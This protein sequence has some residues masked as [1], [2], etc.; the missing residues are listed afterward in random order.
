MTGSCLRLRA[1]V[2]RCLLLQIYLFSEISGA[3]FNPAVT[4]TQFFIGKLGAG[5]K[6]WKRLLTYFGVQVR[7]P[8]NVA[9]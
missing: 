9:K 1:N 8:R 3:S 7:Y 2:R 4:M 6:D 5:N